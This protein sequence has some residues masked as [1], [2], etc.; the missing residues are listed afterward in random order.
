M[1]VFVPATNVIERYNQFMPLN[2]KITMIFLPLSE[3]YLES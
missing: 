2:I 1:K 3:K